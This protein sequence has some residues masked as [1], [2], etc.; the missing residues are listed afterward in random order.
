[1]GILVARSGVLTW[2]ARHRQ[3][4]LAVGVGENS[5]VFVACGAEGGTPSGQP[6]RC[7]RY[8]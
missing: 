1:L 3:G 2:R 4:I 6:A 8:D 5:G 7:R